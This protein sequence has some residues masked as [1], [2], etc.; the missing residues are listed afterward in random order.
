MPNSIPEVVNTKDEWL[1]SQIDVEYPTKASLKGH[2]LQFERSQKCDIVS[3]SPS[4]EKITCP[5]E[6]FPVSFHRLTVYFAILQSKLFSAQKEQ[7]DIIEFF[8]QI[9]YS[10]PCQLFVGFKEQEPMFAAMVTQVNDQMLISNFIS[11]DKSISVTDG[12]QYIYNLLS[13]DVAQSHC[14]LEIGPTI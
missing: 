10:E 13:E 11:T 12:A 8:T 4:Q 1:R 5:F 6:L 7:D 14:Y 9:I 3:W 2:Q